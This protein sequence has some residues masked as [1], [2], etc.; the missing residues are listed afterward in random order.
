MKHIIWK[1]YWNYEKE[2]KWLNDLSAKGL[3][4]TDYSWCRYALEDT[5]PGEYIYRIELLAHLATH[6]ES[7]RYIE[8]VEETGAQCV[9][10]YLR[11]VYFRK[12]AADGAFELYSDI[13]SK[14]RHYKTVRAFWTALAALELCVGASNTVIGI[15]DSGSAINLA[16]GIALFALGCAFVVW[17]FQL[18]RKIRALKKQR[19]IVDA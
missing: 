11:W 5:P 2:E 6:P 15:T 16:L 17:C 13:E 3:A 10:T 7:R 14:I 18:T 12:K 1:A 19:Q 4:M 9:A 8:F